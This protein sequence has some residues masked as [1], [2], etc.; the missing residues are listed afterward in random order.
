MTMSEHPMDAIADSGQILLRDPS[1]PIW[2]EL[3]A[4]LEWL[5][6]RRS[7]IYRGVGVP[8]G[9]GEVV[10]LVPGFLGTDGHLSEL[11]RWLVKIG[12]RVSPSGIDRNIDCPDVSLARLLESAETAAQFGKAPV[13]LIGHSLGGS[14]SRAAAAQRPDL[15]KQV[16][17]LGSP[18][19]QVVAHPL[20]VSV[21]DFI[22]SHLPSP[23]ERPRRHDDH[24]HDGTCSCET[25]AALSRPFPES[26]QR[27][28][29]YTR[30]DGVIDWHT[31]QEEAAEHN[32]EVHGSHLGLVVNREV[33]QV[34]G[35]LLS[36]VKQD[37]KL[38]STTQRSNV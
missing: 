34:I 7:P 20:I 11:R 6:L 9:R 22:E 2:R 27:T 13:S 3:T 33:Y 19:R 31:A 38:L 12:Y 24:F 23:N 37:R 26:V 36:K 1:L 25:L 32:V 28:A 16:I 30:T 29:I 17:T 21:A 14:L 18:I 35:R 8:R 15:I 10:I 5:E 4:W